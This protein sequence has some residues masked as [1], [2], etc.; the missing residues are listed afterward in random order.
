MKKSELRKIIKEEILNEKNLEF[1]LDEALEI[2]LGKLSWY[3]LT[4][5]NLLGKNNI[6]VKQWVKII[7]DLA[8]LDYKTRNSLKEI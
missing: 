8:T 2:A 1:S 4:I 5:E 7:K 3:K 6:F